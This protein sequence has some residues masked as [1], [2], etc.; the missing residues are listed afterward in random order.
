MAFYGNPKRERGRMPN[1]SLT[2]RVRLAGKDVP[3]GTVTVSAAGPARDRL[4]IRW[5]RSGWPARPSLFPQEHS[6]RR[7][8]R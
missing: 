4:T 2:F 8:S 7:S 5:R 6:R 1:P 3:Q